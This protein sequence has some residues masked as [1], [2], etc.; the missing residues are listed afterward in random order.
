MHS[1]F[2]PFYHLRI[3]SGAYVYASVGARYF[4][5][6]CASGHSKPLAVCIYYVQSSQVIVRV[7]S[8]CIMNSVPHML[9]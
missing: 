1:I 3:Y 5:L 8:L 4:L 6:Q 9:L 2:Y 7:P